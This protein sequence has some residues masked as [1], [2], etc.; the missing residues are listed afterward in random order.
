[1]ETSRLK[2]FFS[3]CNDAQLLDNLVR[4]I[5]KNNIHKSGNIDGL[6][7]IV[8]SDVWLLYQHFFIVLDA[9]TTMLLHSP[10]IASILNRRH[11]TKAL[12]FGYLLNKKVAIQGDASKFALLQ[13]VFTFWERDNATPHKMTTATTVATKPKYPIARLAT[14][15]S[16]W[17][18]D[19]YSS[20]GLGPNDFWPDVEFAFKIIS[21]IERNEDGIGA[22][23]VV[24]VLGSLR[25][26]NYLFVPN[27]GE[28]GIQGGSRWQYFEIIFFVN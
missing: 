6:D 18:W 14:E 22:S 24:N 11:V 19:S 8:P 7:P 15:F 20:M 21:N 27:F 28:N 2:D 17:F 13:E 4:V 26:E 16:R 10:N 23:T 25:T 1:M 12:L 9:I 3:F 5:T